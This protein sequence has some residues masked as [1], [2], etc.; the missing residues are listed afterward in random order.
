MAV[1]WCSATSLHGWCHNP[2]PPL[3]SPALGSLSRQPRRIGCV[4]VRREVAVAAAA[5]AAPPEVEAD[6]DMEEEGVECEE[7]CG[8]TGWLLCDFCKG[9][10]NNV[11]SESSPR[12][13]RR[14]P[15]CKAG[16]ILCQR[17]R[18]Y[19]CIT[20]PESTES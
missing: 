14:C 4:S 5:E 8:G 12:I 2:S 6:M 7:G 15:T 9:K 19:R 18:V 1:Q 3:P 13:Y 17:C 20:Y 10:K 16:Y 11:K